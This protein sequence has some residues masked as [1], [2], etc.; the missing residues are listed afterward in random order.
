[1]IYKFR[2]PKRSP[3]ATWKNLLNKCDMCFVRFHCGHLAPAFSTDF[4]IPSLETFRVCQQLKLSRALLVHLNFPQKKE[5][6]FPSLQTTRSTSQ[7]PIT[8]IG[9]LWH[10]STPLGLFPV[11][12]LIE[13]GKESH[14][15]LGVKLKVAGS[16]HAT[17]VSK[18]VSFLLF[19]NFDQVV[20]LPL[21]R[22]M[23]RN[24]QLVDFFERDYRSIHISRR[25]RGL[26]NFS[27]YQL[28]LLRLVVFQLVYF[29]STNPARFIRHQTHRNV[30][31]KS[32][33]RG[34]RSSNR[35]R[36]CCN[37]LMPQLPQRWGSQTQEK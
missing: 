12:Q 17:E 24:H 25:I 1:M 4:G 18:E 6:N 2:D 30:D 21:L 34:W 27:S 31:K 16:K 23:I 3:T 29:I 13:L 37:S 19:S 36:L 33:R 15:S 11:F 14:G 28:A 8:P 10:N 5:D 9:D 22:A 26:Y 7:T 35:A 32:Y 20:V